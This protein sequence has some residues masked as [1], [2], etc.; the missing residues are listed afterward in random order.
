GA[1]SSDPDPLPGFGGGIL[2]IGFLTLNGVAITDNT[3]PEFGGGIIND[4]GEVQIFNSSITNNTAGQGGGGI[5]NDPLD[6]AVIVVNTTVSGNQAEFGG[7]ISEFT[8]SVCFTAETKVLM[9]DGSYKR[10]ID[11]QPG[12]HVMSYDFAAG[13]RVSSLV[14]NTYQSQAVGYLRINGLEVTRKHPFAVGNDEWKEAWQLKVGDR[15]LGLGG[16]LTEIRSIEY[17]NEGTPVY[18][19]EVAG[20]H[21]FYVSDGEHEYL[22]HNKLMPQPNGNPVGLI[23]STVTDNQADT[24]GGGVYIEATFQMTAVASIIAGNTVSGAG[25]NPDCSGGIYSEGFN[26]VQDVTGCTIFEALNPGTDLIGADPLLGP[27]QDNGGPTPT[28]ALLA[29]SPAV[30]LAPNPSDYCGPLGLLVDQ[31]G[32]ARP[33]GTNCDSGAYEADIPLVTIN[34]A[35]GQ[36]D[37][38]GATPIHFTAVFSEPVTGFS[39]SGVS[40]SGSAGATTAVVTEIA[41]NDGTTYDVAV[42]GMTS[43]GTVIADIQAGAAQDGDSN[44]NLASASADNTVTYNNLPPEVLTNG[45]NTAADTGDGVLSEFEN[46]SVDVTQFIVTFDQDVYD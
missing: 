18:N 3:A 31:R 21:N 10:I 45:V 19:L 36:S 25:A 14:E 8:T 6:G 42:S 23:F 40:L 43:N 17:V 9:S 1:F 32:V 30:N 28:H 13:Q 46:V 34:Q 7:G 26:L 20:V 15:V 33:Q 16:G 5:S 27:L 44:A 35:A 2:N 29:G 24:D 41:P 37:P 39:D 11:V 12:D 4:G 38:T 22:V